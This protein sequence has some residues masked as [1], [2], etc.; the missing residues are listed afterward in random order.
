MLTN[1]IEAL[2]ENERNE[3]VRDFKGFVTY[4]REKGFQTYADEARGRQC[5]FDVARVQRCCRNCLKMVLEHL[6][7]GSILKF[8]RYM[9]SVTY[10]EACQV[11]GLSTPKIGENQACRLKVGSLPLP[12]LVIVQCGPASRTIR[13]CFTC[14]SR[15]EPTCDRKIRSGVAPTHT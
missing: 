11:S 15:L 5:A 8:S 10:L 1:G 6:I 4:V 13:F 12:T 2:G 14:I 9:K 3:Y 7:P